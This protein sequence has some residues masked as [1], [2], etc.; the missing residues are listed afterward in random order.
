MT[1][2]KKEITYYENWVLINAYFYSFWISR[3]EFNKYNTNYQ[4]IS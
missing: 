4:N 1:Q 3:I 2:N